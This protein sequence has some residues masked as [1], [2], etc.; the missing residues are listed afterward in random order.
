MNEFFNRLKKY[1]VNPSE[2]EFNNMLQDEEYLDSDK[3][4]L[5]TCFFCNN[6]KFDIIK[7][8]VDVYKYIGDKM[9]SHEDI[10]EVHQLGLLCNWL[11]FHGIPIFANGEKFPNL[12]LLICKNCGKILGVYLDGWRFPYLG[13]LDN[14]ENINKQSCCELPYSINNLIAL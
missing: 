10:E 7:G 8:G 6:D 4:I 14:K 12:Q 11:N 1:C 13:Y 9:E 3:K 2:E 5:N